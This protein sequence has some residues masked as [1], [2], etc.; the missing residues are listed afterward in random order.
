MPVGKLCVNEYESE[1]SNNMSNKT[2]MTGFSGLDKV[3]GGFR[4]GTLNVISGRPGMG[5]T[6]LALNIAMNA[7]KTSGKSVVYYSLEKAR[8]EIVKRLLLSELTYT[9]EADTAESIKTILR[10]FE[11][12]PIHIDDRSDLVPELI[13]ERYENLLSEK[14]DI[15]LVIVD[16]LQLFSYTKNCF[17]FLPDSFCT[18]GVTLIEIAMAASTHA[19]KMLAQKYEVPVV[20][21]SQCWKGADYRKDHI[22]VL[23]DIRCKLLRQE[24]DSVIFIVKPAYYIDD[25]ES[26]IED[27]CHDRDAKIIVAKNR[28]GDSDVSITVR[29]HIR[30]ACFTDKTAEVQCVKNKSTERNIEDYSLFDVVG[31]D[32]NRFAL[33]T[34]ISVAQKPG[35]K[36]VNPLF[37]FGNYGLGKTLLL[38]VI[39]KYIKDKN[40]D[41]KVIYTTCDTF[42]AEFI[43]CIKSKE[44]SNFR[45]YY[46]TADVLLFD[47][48]QLLVGKE[49][50]KTEFYNTFQALLDNN[51]QVVITCDRNPRDLDLPSELISLFQSGILLKISA[52][53]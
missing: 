50:V 8:T 16:Y 42:T 25:P 14:N 5:K 27:V 30:T 34:A 2:I 31:G 22:P 45:D 53:R 6:S 33:K 24:A 52:P 43:N 39:E 40:P 29:W 36:H 51:K 23:D 10:G 32:L 1:V 48:I 15:G 49:G 21:L 17:G 3:L 20:V 37:L 28:F 18:D 12:L 4:P 19:L 26:N 38:K 7:V 44:Y 9:S 46:R 41:K 47:D 35:D 13:M 11:D